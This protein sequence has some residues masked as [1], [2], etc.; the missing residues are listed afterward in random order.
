MTRQRTPLYLAAGILLVPSF[1]PLVLAAQHQEPAKAT[2][3]AVALRPDS[4]GDARVEGDKL[5][6][7]GIALTLP[8]GW[9]QQPIEN[10]GPMAPKAV[11]QLPVGEGEQEAGVVR[12]THYPEMK[13]KDDL[14]IDRWLAQVTQ[15]DGKPSTREKAKI[16]NIEAGGAKL[17]IVDL[18]GD[19]KLTMRDKPRPGYRMIGAIVNHP[20]G[21]HFIVAAATIEQMEK[22][23]EQVMAFLKSIKVN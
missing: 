15:P 4:A 17:T 14:N 6:L 9:K 20:Q 13:G 5:I 7:T 1:G 18:R 21:P 8:A 11:F 16:E 10:P 19:V 3:P 2:K 12:I 23:Q 22:T